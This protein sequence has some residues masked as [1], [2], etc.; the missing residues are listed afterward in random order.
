MHL[1]NLMQHE[2]FFEI[3]ECLFDAIKKMFVRHELHCS[4]IFFDRSLRRT[5]D[6]NSTLYLFID[7]V[8]A[9]VV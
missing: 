7:H 5:N 9:A 6:T 1:L 8:C 2:L 3:Y 4:I